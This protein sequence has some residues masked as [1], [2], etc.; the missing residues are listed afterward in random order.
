MNA[1][2]PE[3]TLR[4]YFA[5]IAGSY[6]ADHVGDEHTVALGHVAALARKLG[7]SS[8][9]DVGCGTARGLQQLAEELP[10]LE[11]CGADISFEMLEQGRNKGISGAKLIQCDGYHLPVPDA[12][13]DAVCELGLLH[14]VRHPRQVISEMC[15]VARKAVFLSDHNRFG[16]GL[17]PKRLL[18]L[19]LHKVGLWDFAFYLR[20]GGKGYGVSEGDGV[21]YSYSVFDSYPQLAKWADQILTIPILGSPAYPLLTAHHVL[22]AAFRGSRT[23]VEK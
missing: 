18:K 20:T 19:L 16:Q 3:V 1:R 12:S 15:R 5:R 22:V 2:N 4:E 13:F 6:D 10:G 7:T 23:G 9:L 17:L 8:I 21:S 14:H 11:L